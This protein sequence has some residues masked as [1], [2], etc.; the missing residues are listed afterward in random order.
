MEETCLHGHGDRWPEGDTWGPGAPVLGHEALVLRHCE[1]LQC[2]SQQNEPAS[3]LVPKSVRAGCLRVRGKKHSASAE[4]PL[5]KLYPGS[6]L[7]PM[8]PRSCEINL[9][10][11]NTFCLSETLQNF[12]SVPLSLF[13]LHFTNFLGKI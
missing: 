3:P 4:Q 8:D 1:L 10:L 12:S 9:A 6:N 7:I 2:L 13:S 5:I 11:L